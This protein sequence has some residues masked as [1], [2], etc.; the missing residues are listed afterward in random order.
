MSEYKNVDNKLVETSQQEVNNSY[1][2]EQIKE[3]LGHWTKTNENALEQIS[4]WEKLLSQANDNGLKTIEEV[5][6]KEMLDREKA[7]SEKKK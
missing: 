2:I 6:E 3:Q 1:S 7:E 4:Y 5:A